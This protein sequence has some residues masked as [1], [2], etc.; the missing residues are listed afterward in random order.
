MEKY[1]H[2]SFQVTGYKITTTK[3]NNKEAKDIADAWAKFMTDNMADKILHK[4]YPTLHMV[5][6][7]YVD[8]YN[9][10]ERGYDMLLG[11]MTELNTEQVDKSLT[12]IVV[13]PQDYEYVKVDGELPKN[14]ILEW[15]KVNALSKNECKRAF[16]YDM[17]MYNADMT[18]V[19]LTVSVNK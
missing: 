2:G 5:Y 11:F 18:G 7:N 16:G 3:K 13:P 6:Y 8:A 15:Q 17:D 19:T 1:S 10:E 12:T 9:L 14:L 4:A